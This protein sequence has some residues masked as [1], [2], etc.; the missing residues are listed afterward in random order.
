VAGLPGVDSVGWSAL[1]Q[2]SRWAVE[3]PHQ[4]AAA[5]LNMRT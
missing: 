1:V 5:A 3:L 4:E 2:P